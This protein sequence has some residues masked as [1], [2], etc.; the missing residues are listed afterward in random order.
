MA[1][2]MPMCAVDCPWMYVSDGQCDIA[3]YNVEC[4]MD[5]GDCEQ[6]RRKYRTLAVN[7]IIIL[8]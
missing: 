7:I 2:S 8:M 6:V 5:G 1:W 3:C 4:Q